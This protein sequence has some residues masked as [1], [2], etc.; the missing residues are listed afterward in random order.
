MSYSSLRI[1]WVSPAFGE[2]RLLA[3]LIDTR[4]YNPGKDEGVTPFQE[5]DGDGKVPVSAFTRRDGPRAI[6]SNRG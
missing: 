3:V 6:A 1:P 2:Q 4:S 5:D